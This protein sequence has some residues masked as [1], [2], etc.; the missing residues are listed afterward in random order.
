MK[1]L[2]LTNYPLPFIAE[3]VGLPVTVNEGWLIGLSELLIQ[4]G[5]EIVLCSA[6][7]MPQEKIQYQ[8]GNVIFYGVK[9]SVASGYNA[10][11][12]S[13]FSKIL[14]REIPDIVHI[15]G[16]EFPHSYSMYEACE[17]LGIENKCVVSLQGLIAKIAL[18]YD[19]EIEPKYKKKRLLWDSIIGDSV[20]LNK[21][22]F[23]MRGRYEE[24]LLGKI[25]NVIGRTEWDY[26]CVKQLNS[27]VQYHKCNEI[28]RDVFYENQWEYEKCEKHSVIISQATYPVKGFHILLKAAALLTDKYPDFKILVPSHVVYPKAMKRC[29]FLNSDYANYIVGLIRKYQLE[30]HIEFLGSL[31]AEKMCEAYLRSNVFVCAS[32]I[33]NSSNSLGEAMLLGMPVVASYVGGLSSMMTHGKEGFFFPLEEE[34][35]LAGY[36]DVLF[37]D[38]YKAVSLGKEAHM[39]A[40]ITHD[41]EQNLGDLLAC[42][43]KIMKNESEK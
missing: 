1:I 24:M 4:K 31:N 13:E 36:I 33:E 17:M 28:L 35:M 30:E 32:T 37:E 15:M 43:Q 7:D 9:N 23:S 2:W 12:K 38:R 5:W 27:E 19:L 10:N 26:F 11:L 6:L 29:R 34:Y 8:N 40:L 42:Y 21:R 3:K 14:E 16:S 18:A 25:R 39:R 22:D 41:K 20:L